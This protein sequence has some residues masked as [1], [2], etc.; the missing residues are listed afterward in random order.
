MQLKNQEIDNKIE[1]DYVV[2]NSKNQLY[3]REFKEQK[4]I[5]II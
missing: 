3:L 2:E 1:I 4:F 5:L